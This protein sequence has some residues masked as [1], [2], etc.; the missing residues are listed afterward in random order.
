MYANAPL[1]HQALF[2][3][4]AIP[5]RPSCHTSLRIAPITRYSS[6]STLFKTRQHSLFRR[7]SD[8]SGCPTLGPPYRLRLAAILPRASPPPTARLESPKNATLRRRQH[9]TVPRAQFAAAPATRAGPEQPPRHSRRL[10]ATR[11][12]SETT[13]AALATSC[14]NDSRTQGLF[15]CRRCRA[16]P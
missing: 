8:P 3:F 16:A 15:R 11:G 1:N 6:P 7:R 10:L 2:S 12:T 14:A 13:P 5:N 9:Q 4:C